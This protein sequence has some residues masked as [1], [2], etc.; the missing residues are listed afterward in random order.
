MVKVSRIA[1]T[2]NRFGNQF[3]NRILSPRERE[4]FN[5]YTR[6]KSQ[7]L[8]SRYSFSIPFTLDGRSRRLHTRRW[9][10]W[11]FRSGPSK[12]FISGREFVA[13]SLL[14][15]RERQRKWQTRQISRSD[16][17]VSVT[18]SHAM[19]LLV[20]KT[21][22]VLPSLFWKIDSM[23]IPQRFR[24]SLYNSTFPL[25]LCFF[26]TLYQPI[27]LTRGSHN[28]RNNVRSTAS[29]ITTRRHGRNGRTLSRRHSSILAIHHSHLP[30]HT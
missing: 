7:F 30:P 17:I 4:D 24:F 6:D 21:I 20:M 10:R 16:C 2:M 23:C 26:Y 1:S 25:L 3:V 9:V 18:R 28:L 19:Y 27:V 8:A 15:S 12:C 13:L 22:T 14:S 29:Q 11:V 5:R